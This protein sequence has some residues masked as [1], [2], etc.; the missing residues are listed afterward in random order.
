MIVGGLRRRIIKDNFYNMLYDS[1][2]DLGWFNGS[3]TLS[4]FPVTLVAE[5]IDP[6]T[7][8]KPNKIGISTEDLRSWNIEMGSNLEEYKWS[9]Y[10]DIFAE[11]EST[12][13]HLSGDIYDVISGK[14]E[15]IG[16]TGP[17]L[18]VY[19]Y[20]TDGE[21]YLFTCQLENIQME[22]VREWDKQF[23]KYWWVIGFELSDT[24][25]GEGG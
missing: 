24:Y 2:S 11:D 18:D 15:S 10:I 9:I 23:N 14:M 4:K 21:P 25:F 3:L 17:T 5:Q 19:D 20:M 22:R 1:L 6:Q 13:I 7:E 16:R 8:I 12:G